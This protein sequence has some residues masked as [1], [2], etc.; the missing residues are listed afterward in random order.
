MNEVVRRH[1]PILFALFGLAAGIFVVG[2]V[3][4]G[5]QNYKTTQAVRET[6]VNNHSLLTTIIGLSH[7]INDCT[8]PTGK[9]FKDGQ[10]RTGAAVASISREA[11]VRSACGI[12]L[13]R[14][15]N[16]RTPLEL[17]R[18]ITSC[19]TQTLADLNSQ[20]PSP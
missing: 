8:K 3:W 4:V 2:A 5:V 7:Q 10:Q 19:I 14:E 20:H 11:I 17:S 12:I 9:C 16:A 1:R 18:Q 6:Q 15:S 13:S